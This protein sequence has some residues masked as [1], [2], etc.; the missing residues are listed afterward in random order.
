MRP[1]NPADADLTGSR[2]A[3][4]VAVR[5][6]GL[7]FFDS[8]ALLTEGRGGTF[9]GVPVRP[10]ATCRPAQEPVLYAGSRR[11]V[12]YHARGENQKGALGRHHPLLPDPGG[13][14]ALCGE[15]AESTATRSAFRDDDVA[16]DRP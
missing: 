16:A 15:R 11:G 8:L 3:Q 7:N 13:H 9:N 12:P 10:G 14:R 2:R 6:L 4:P 1:A 5:G